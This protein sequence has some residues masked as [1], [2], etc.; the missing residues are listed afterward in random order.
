MACGAAVDRLESD[1]QRHRA[2]FKFLDT[3]KDRGA[4]EESRSMGTTTVQYSQDGEE[5]GEE[6][7]YEEYYDEEYEDSMSGDQEEELPQGEETEFLFEFVLLASLTDA[8]K[9][10]F[11]SFCLVFL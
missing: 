5:E 1:R 6:E 10:G 9:C 8:I 7:Y 2:V 4:E 11:P 3:T